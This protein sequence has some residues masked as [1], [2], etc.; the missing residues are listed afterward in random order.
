MSRRGKK[1]KI[2][3]KGAD[4]R[5]SCTE[6]GSKKGERPRSC[7]LTQ[8]DRH[9]GIESA[10]RRACTRRGGGSSRRSKPESD[11]GA[12]VVIAVHGTRRP[13]NPW[14]PSHQRVP[15]EREKKK[16]AKEGE[17]S[18]H[19][20]IDDASDKVRSSQYAKGKKNTKQSARRAEGSSCP[21]D[22]LRLGKTCYVSLVKNRRTG[23]HWKKG[24]RKK[25]N[26]QKKTSPSNV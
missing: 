24:K 4:E 17:P 3:A 9:G 20:P 5:K 12:R 22:S 15:D 23:E 1:G 18:A 14:V 19:R 25:K 7:W 26:P 21:I 10:S 13:R 6:K 2:A 11:K 16:T 8:P